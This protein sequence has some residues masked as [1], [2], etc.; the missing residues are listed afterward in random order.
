MRIIRLILHLYLNLNRRFV[1]LIRA[2]IFNRRKTAMQHCFHFD[3]SFH[4]NSFQFRKESQIYF[5]KFIFDVI[6]LSFNL[7][8]WFQ[9]QVY[10]YLLSSH[11]SFLFFFFFAICN[12]SIASKIWQ[13]VTGNIFPKDAS[14]HTIE[15]RIF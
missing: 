11:F 14:Y 3:F 5:C 4:L 10:D 9:G 2:G 13:N 7:R 12:W 1:S 8:S 15:I 6:S